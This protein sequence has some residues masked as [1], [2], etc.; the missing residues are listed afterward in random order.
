M[1]PIPG[2]SYRDLTP[3][4]IETIHLNY[5]KVKR[6][7]DEEKPKYQEALIQEPKKVVELKELIKKLFSMQDSLFKEFKGRDPKEVFDNVVSGK[8]EL[9]RND[10]FVVKSLLDYRKR[11]SRGIRTPEKIIEDIRNNEE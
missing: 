9:P 8:E 2:K 1:C 4:Q 10:Q 11:L 3:K 7:I 6:T 5:N